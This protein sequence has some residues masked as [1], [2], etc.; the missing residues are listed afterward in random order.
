MKARSSNRRSPV[1]ITRSRPTTSPWWA[2]SSKPLCSTVPSNGMPSGACSATAAGRSYSSR[3][4]KPYTLRHSGRPQC[5]C[6]EKH[7]HRA[8][9]GDPERHG[10]PVLARERSGHDRSGE[11]SEHL[12]EQRRE[13]DGGA[14]QMPG[15]GIGRHEHDADGADRLTA[16]SQEEDQGKQPEIPV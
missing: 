3:G 16:L 11:A 2:A 15:D 7:H 6:D 13:T 8:P 5:D 4:G 12:A 14:D 10:K 9:A 1:S